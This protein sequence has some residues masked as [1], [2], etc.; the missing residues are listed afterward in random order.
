VITVNFAVLA[1][2]G[3]DFAQRIPDADGLRLWRTLHDQNLGRVAIVVDDDVRSDLLEYW[4]K[5]HSI[6]A[7]MYEIL[8]STDPVIKAE[9]VHRM[10]GS[11]GRPNDWYVD[12]DPRTA[13]QT[14]ALGIPTLLMSVPYVVRPEWGSSQRTARQWGD[15]VDEID[16]QAIMRAERN[17]NEPEDLPS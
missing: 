10:L 17:W 8:D 3:I 11:M 16:R 7:A 1:K 6:K 5:S 12:V 15:L 14:L 4:L 13:A 2:P 9:K